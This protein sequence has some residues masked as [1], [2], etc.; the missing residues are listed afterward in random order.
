MTRAKEGTVVHLDLASR[1]PNATCAFLQAALGWRFSPA[2]PGYDMFLAPDA[3]H[4]GLRPLEAGEAPRV[5][6]YVAVDDLDAARQRIEKAGGRVLTGPDEVPGFG[7]ML[8]F[9]APGGVALGA[10]QER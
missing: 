7:R 2:M 3:P 1:D 4:G 10:F 9:E 5:L 6:A 8:T